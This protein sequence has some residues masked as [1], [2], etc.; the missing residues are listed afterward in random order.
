MIVYEGVGWVIVCVSSFDWMKPFW[1]FTKT[2]E[3][4]KAC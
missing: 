3:Q 2:A 1:V 4:G